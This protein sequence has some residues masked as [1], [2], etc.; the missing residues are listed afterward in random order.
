MRALVDTHALYWYVEG[1]LQLSTTA[2][3]I[4]QDA[5]NEVLISPAS[6]WEMAIKRMPG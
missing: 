2:R 5:S 3:T 6:Y 1:D 4:M